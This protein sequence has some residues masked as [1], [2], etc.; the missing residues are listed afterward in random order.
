[1][2]TCG[3]VGQ[4]SSRVLEIR[5]LGGLEVVRDGVPATLPPS[6][7]T[8]ALLAYLALA[9]GRH[10]REQ[11][12]DMFWDVPDD[13]R[14]SLRWSLSKIRPIV[15]EV[16]VPRLLA[17]RQS[18]E[19]RTEATSV[20]LL[21]AQSCASLAGVAVDDLADVA[22]SFRGPLLSDLDLS[23]NSGFH[24]WLLGMREDARKLQARLLRS[25]VERLA[26]TPEAALPYARELVGVDP[27]DEDAWA[28]LIATLA[29][30]GRSGELRP[31]FEAGVRTL[32]DVGGGFGS[33]LRAWRAA[34]A[35]SSR[36]DD[37]AKA[38]ESPA[39]Y[40]ASIVVLPFANLSDDPA[41][42]FFADGI[43]CE[44]TTDLS[45][46]PDMLVI[47]RN[48]A[49]T[50]RN[51]RIDTRQIGRELSVRCVLEGEV[52]R[53]GDQVRV[54]VQL[55]D[56][57]NDAHLWAER[58]TGEARDL[59]S[60]QDQIT[61]RIAVALD[62]ELVD[63]EASRQ[64]EAPDTRDYILRGRAA[65]LRPP[66]RENR[67][68]QVLLFERALAL[69]PQSVGA[70]SWLAIELAA[71]AIDLMTDTIGADIAR[72]EDLAKR[73]L[74]VAPRY[75]V[76]RFAMAQVLRAQHR[77]DEAIAEYEA[78][79]GLNRNWAHAYSHLG[80]CKLMTGS[81]EELIP[82]QEEAIRL[83]PRDPQIGLFYS[84]IGRAHL[85]Q[86]RIDEAVI[87]CEKARNATP[88]AA[89]FRSF[90]ASSCALKG[91]IQRA[92]A[93]LAEARRLVADD[94][95]ASIRRVRAVTSWGTPAICG[96]AE[97]TYLAGL[98][99]AGMPDE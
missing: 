81:V 27:F 33:L 14:G 19:L 62:L 9:R 89:I 93:E 58:F 13:P 64:I 97:A 56:A 23:E 94:R 6:R 63:V 4:R 71:R 43:T 21:A 80:W 48:T 91:D 95:Y 72:A 65:R 75:S 61:R 50:Y 83:S 38:T 53:S 41:Q 69:D 30:A 12:C 86:S 1:M 17:D 85:L 90:L 52:Q 55:I 59:F 39:G 88:A 70:Q 84:R 2:L 5:V 79:I 73:A 11:L 47:S 57:E 29:E 25:L 77:Y 67:A 40:R 68:E 8:R 32:R 78:V 37:N 82:A 15:D 60:L 87:W 10:R 76:A 66:S 36:P 16:S 44:L 7:K 96:L 18:V 74:A 54:T 99:M 28:L 92:A 34:Q 3:E 22:K 46:I 42:Q 49:F 24:T 20:D 35:A 98:R 31:Q 51:R 45:R 26:A